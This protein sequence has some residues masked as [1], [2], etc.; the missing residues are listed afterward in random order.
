MTAKFEVAHANLLK[1]ANAV[2]QTLKTAEFVG[3]E[4]EKLAVSSLELSLEHQ[5]SILLLGIHHQY[6]SMFALLRPMAEAY[7]RGRWLFRC[8][9]AKGVTDFAMEKVKSFPDLLAEIE[10]AQPQHS[11]HPVRALVKTLHDFT[12]TGINQLLRRAIGGGHCPDDD[13]EKAYNLSATF[14]LLAGLEL[15]SLATDHAER[16]VKMAR[17]SPDFPPRTA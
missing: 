3:G 4:K 15:A 1:V 2:N 9:D 6:G 8:A 14:A 16:V 5:S 13:I 11:M 7:V 12:H 17:C 10:A